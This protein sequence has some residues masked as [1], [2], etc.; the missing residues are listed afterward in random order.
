[1]AGVSAAFGALD[2]DPAVA[3]A[4]FRSVFSFRSRSITPP[5]SSTTS[6]SPR[7]VSFSFHKNTWYSVTKTLGEEMYDGYLGE[8]L[9]P[10]APR[11]LDFTGKMPVRVH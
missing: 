8:P 9:R 7:A 1:M 11:R 6:R 4:V 2:L 3:R 10:T 5:R